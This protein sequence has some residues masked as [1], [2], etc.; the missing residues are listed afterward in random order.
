MVEV[1]WGS[2]EWVVNR[3]LMENCLSGFREE[4]VV[5]K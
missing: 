5:M 1:L 2:V 3:E 4:W